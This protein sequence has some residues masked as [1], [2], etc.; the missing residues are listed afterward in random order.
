MFADLIAVEAMLLQPFQQSVLE[1]GEISLMVMDGRVSHAIRKT[2]KAN[3]FRVQDDHGGTVHAH[4]ASA[5]E[6]AFAEAAVAAVPFDVIY[7]R[8][9]VIPRQRRPTGHHGAGNGRA[10]LF[11]RFGRRR[12]TGRWHCPPAGRLNRIDSPLATGRARRRFC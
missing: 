10:E 9:D 4:E 7:A 11:F 3:D 1:Q 8:V 2:P 5:E 12:S 6:I